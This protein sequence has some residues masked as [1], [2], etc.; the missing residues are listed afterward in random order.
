MRSPFAAVM[1]CLVSFNCY[2]QRAPAV[3]LLAIAIGRPYPIRPLSE[4]KDDNDM[5]PYRTFLAPTPTASKLSMFSHYEV[6]TM[7]DNGNVREL[8]AQRAYDSKDSCAH[9]LRAVVASVTAVHAVVPT[10]SDV[11]LFEA[12]R[13]D[14]FV[15][16][17]CHYKN[18]SPYPTLFLRI[19]SKSESAR[20]DEQ[21][22][23]AI[24]RRIPPSK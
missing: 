13:N 16:A 2:A 9:A 6:A 4:E 22:K 11:S 10:R 1:L 18:W 21:L 20:A 24:A 23:Q 15:R 3:D 14:V 17:S 7:K 12:S 5:L 19:E 8:T